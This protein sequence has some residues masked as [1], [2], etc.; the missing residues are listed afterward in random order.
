MLL[1]GVDLGGDYQR[2]TATVHG[3]DLLFTVDGIIVRGPEPGAERLVAW[4]GLDSASARARARQADGSTAM[5]L[6]LQSGSETVRFFLPADRVTA[7]QAAYLD[8]ALPFW[9]A[10]YGGTSGPE[11][12]SS[13]AAVPDAANADAAVS[14][15]D[16]A[17]AAVS[18]AAGPPS[19][20]I[21]E[22][23]TTPQ[24]PSTPQA[25]PSPV[26]PSPSAPVPP[27]VP[28]PPAGWVTP[29][30]GPVP[31]TTPVPPGGWVTPPT[32]PGPPTT[33]VAP[34]A[35]ATPAGSVPPAAPLP[36]ASGPGAPAMQP[37]ESGPE[38]TNPRRFMRRRTLFVA[39]GTLVA[40]VIAGA[41]YLA[42]NNSGTASVSPT[43]TPRTA[44][45]SADQQLVN[46]INLRL[47]DL[48]A[49]WTRVPPIGSALT[50]AQKRSQAQAVDQFA[51]CLGMPQTFIGGL[52]GTL[53]QKDQSAAGDSPTFA[54]AATATTIAQSH[55]TVVKTATDATADAVPFTKSNFTSCFSQFQ[56][57]SASAQVSG[58]TA[59]TATATLFPPPTGVGAYGFVT[60]STLPGHGSVVTE[61]IFMIGGRSETG[62]TL[63]AT[64]TSIAPD[65]VNSAYSAMVQRIAAAGKT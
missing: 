60:T 35:W 64:G 17:D 1:T 20:D 13:D 23:S 31:P 55:T 58:G 5:V 61:I 2:G 43:T 59:Q 41:V 25:P 32:V 48:P 28:V 52:F 50:P 33:P 37:I 3:V 62:L 26:V 51:G 16:S 34:A 46:S 45:P 44:P 39:I 21:P 9:L 22:G 24:Q 15:A 38:P 7:G 14:D 8:H 4:S 42:T 10:R 53:A 12:G 29:P 56:N 18:D 19:N 40:V 30:V 6:V 49:G 65:V 47:T 57:A 11:A 63:Q 36:T 27:T 54:G